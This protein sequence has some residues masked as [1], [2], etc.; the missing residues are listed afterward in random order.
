MVTRRVSAY[1]VGVTETLP[2][3][4]RIARQFNGPNNSA[5]GG[6]VAGLIGARMTGGSP[7]ATTVDLRKPPPLETDLEWVVDGARTDLRHQDVT[8]ASG[9][10]GELD[11]RDPL[12][13]PVDT[14]AARAARDAYEGY[15]DHPF[16]RCFTCGSARAQGDG[17][18]LFS[19]PLPDGRMACPWTPHERFGDADGLL[20][21]PYMWAAL[22]CP[23]GWAAHIK[24][25]PMVLARMTASLYRRPRVGEECV[26]VG[27]LRGVERR[28]NLTA[29]ALY[30][31]DGELL[32]RADQIWIAI[33][34]EDFA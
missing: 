27:A 21:P 6:Y 31:E 12:V 13:A 32:G 1:P 19:G 8:V 14:A 30:G 16:P 5:N 33:D 17:L 23:G 24:A 20:A 10:A 4:A 22:D 34:I 7:A 2:R 29:T 15:E 25:K 18:R 3:T 11:P 28:K 9:R 26:A